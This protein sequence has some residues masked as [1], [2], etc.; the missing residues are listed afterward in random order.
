MKNEPGSMPYIATKDINFGH[1]VNYENGVYIPT[2]KTNDF[3]VAP[4]HSILICSEGGSAGKKV[5]IIDRPV[6]YVNKLYAISAHKDELESKYIFYWCLS[7]QFKSDFFDS[8][9]GLIGG[10]SKNK[11]VDLKIPV[12][13]IE[14]QREIVRILD[15]AFERIDAALANVR[16][17]IINTDELFQSKLA[18]IFS[19]PD[20]SWQTK[21]LGESTSFLARGIPPKYTTVNGLGVLNQK[22]IRNHKISTE[23]SR[24]H[25]ETEKSVNLDKKI[26]LGDV[27]V[28]ST[29]T[30]TLGRVAQVRTREVVGMTVDTHVT[31]VRPKK[32][33]FNIEYFGWA[34][35]LIEKEI[36]DSGE[37]TSGQTEL[38]RKKLAE[39]F[40]I[41]IPPIERQKEIVT[42]LDSLSKKTKLLN[43]KYKTEEALLLELK[44][45]LLQKAFTG[46]LT[47]NVI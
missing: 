40:N 25:D 7:G 34:M 10:V 29:G 36:E 9:T 6:H 38:P 39:N 41:P 19:N 23:E 16:Q 15:S 22:C 24:L 42:V 45:S 1:R 32:D 37:G 4:A 18:Q 11:F 28:N 13:P 21:T 5:A 3:R 17:N 33:I 26:I 8:M 2:G 31:I 43:K 47:D 14:E 35:I 27:L 20:P 44:K 12:P 46:N 30:G